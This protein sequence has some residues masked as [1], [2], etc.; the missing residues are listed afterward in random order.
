MEKRLLSILLT[1][2]TAALALGGASTVD[3]QKETVV[4]LSKAVLFTADVVAIDHNERV[5]SLRDPDG[6]VVVLEVGQDARNLDQIVPG[7]QLKIEASNSVVLYL[8]RPG[9]QHEG[10]V[11]ERAPKGEKPAGIAVETVDMTATIKSIDKEE[12]AVVL[13]LPDGKNVTT[14]AHKSDKP[15]ESLKVGDSFYA[16]LTRSIAISVENR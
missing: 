3:A 2:I 16:R 4:E 11:V 6:N 15:F 14:K 8:D 9:T 1:F 12:R 13:E 7:D 10:I 5:V